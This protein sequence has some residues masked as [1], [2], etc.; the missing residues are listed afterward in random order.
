[1]QLNLKG[2][3]LSTYERVPYVNKETGIQQETT[4][5]LQLLVEEKLKNGA[6]KSELYDV[7]IDQNSI[8]KYKDKK[9]QL[10]DVVCSIYSRSP[11]SLT[12]I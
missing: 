8:N 10:I 9:G 7:K 11:I 1:M 5:G 12:A 6:V 3:M 4:Y 2:T